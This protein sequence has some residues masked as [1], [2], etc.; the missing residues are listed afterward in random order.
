MNKFIVFIPLFIAGIY[1][2]PNFAREKLITVAGELP[3]E[4][5]GIT[6]IHEHILVDWIGADSTGYHRWDK[7]KVVERVQPFLLKAKE[8]GVNTFFECTPDYL[9]RDPFLLKK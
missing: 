9:G 6:L 2:H 5:M 4:E 7:A 3:V 8:K 1:C